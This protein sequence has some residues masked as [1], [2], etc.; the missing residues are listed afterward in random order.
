MKSSKIYKKNSQVSEKCS[1]SFKKYLRIQKIFMILKQ[2]ANLYRNIHE[3]QK[4]SQFL[5]MFGNSTKIH[6]FKKQIRFQ[7]IKKSGKKIKSK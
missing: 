4:C 3:S 6:D 5:K 1:K 2:F 7:K